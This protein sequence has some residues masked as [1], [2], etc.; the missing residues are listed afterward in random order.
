[1]PAPFRVVTRVA[2]IS[3]TALALP[4]AVRPVAAQ[5]P[6]PPDSVVRSIIQQRVDGGRNAGIVVGIID[7]DGS[8]RWTAYGRG[9]SGPLDDHTLFEIGPVTG[10][11]TATLFADMVAKGLVRHD[12]PVAELLPPGTVIPGR[13]GRTMTLWNLATHTAGLPR[14]PPGL[15]PVDPANP[16]AGFDAKR[17]LT[18]LSGHALPRDIGATFEYSPLG[19]GLLGY[20]LAAKAGGS[21]EQLLTGRVLRPLQLEETAIT[22]TPE[23]RLRLAPGHDSAGKPAK[24]R[25]YGALAGAGALHSTVH[26][27]LRYLAV[28]ITPLGSPVA[29]GL[30]YAGRMHFR[31]DVP[32]LSLG[33]AWQRIA[34][35]SGDTL[36]THGG[37][38]AGY[39]AFVGFDPRR[40]VAVVVL[41]SSGSSVD[42]I[43][44]HLLD[45]NAPLAPTPSR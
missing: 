7:P 43:G 30:R 34:T 19:I 36:V 13:G 4:V 41:S 10:T 38:T 37:T 27:L 20:A 14:V 33:L 6:L 18:F 11:F 3:F 45:P 17:M 12:Q 26:D 23:M 22:L 28:N 16:Y 42:D 9:D 40:R 15:A 21:Y 39:A 32:A 29:A 44:L 25:D 5:R 1:M 24:S 31:T 2:L 8:T 35:P